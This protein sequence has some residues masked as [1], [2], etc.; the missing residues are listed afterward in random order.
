[1]NHD[2]ELWQL[3]EQSWLG[4]ADFYERALAQGAR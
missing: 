2:E 3:E 4:G 1:M